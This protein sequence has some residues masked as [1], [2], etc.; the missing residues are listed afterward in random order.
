MD[1]FQIFN[2]TIVVITAL[3]V[4]LLFTSS[5]G[6]KKSVRILGVYMFVLFI[7]NLLF[8]V[9]D[10]GLISKNI[11]FFFISLL[12]LT[13]TPLFYMYIKSLADER[14]SIQK[15]LVVHFFPAFLVAL[16]YAI[17]FMLFVF[18]ISDAFL[19]FKKW[20]FS[21]T[22][23]IYCL[24]FITYVILILFILKKFSISIRNNFSDIEHI[25]L[26]WLKFCIWLYFIY[27]PSDLLMF[28]FLDYTVH[29]R[30]WIDLHYI[31]FIFLLGFFGLKQNEIYGVLSEDR[32]IQ[33]HTD[34]TK[35][36]DIT[37]VSVETV[38]SVENALSKELKETLFQRLDYLLTNERIFLNSALNSHDL[39]KLLNTNR[40]YLSIVIQE[41]FNTNFYNLIN[42]YRV[43]EAK[44]YLSHEEFHKYTL[45]AIAEM[46]GFAT[47]T[48]FYRTFKRLVN[49][50]PAEFKKKSMKLK[51]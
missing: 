5:R 43:E 32:K 48:V 2:N 17:S 29:V 14:F 1:F 16:F 23:L 11:T 37:M 41:K 39:A 46:S 45:D 3:Y 7:W 49:E 19:L 34:I 10:I 18:E 21:I 27:V 15:K 42:S 22:I 8:W 6:S 38:L 25:R 47:R 36:D 51:E 4:F 33:S 26:R 44:K 30:I 31:V 9:L 28:F 35:T 12:Y 50:T 40:T 20:M 24:Q 13:E